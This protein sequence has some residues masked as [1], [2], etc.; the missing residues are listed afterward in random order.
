MFNS[1]E[2]TKPANPK[3][4]NMTTTTEL[5]SL[6]ELCSM[7]HRSPG[8]IRHALDTMGVEPAFRVNGRDV[9][10]TQVVEKLFEHFQNLNAKED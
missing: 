5:H 10:N 1:V 2:R 3:L 8:Q 7:L 6:A 4:E 9:W